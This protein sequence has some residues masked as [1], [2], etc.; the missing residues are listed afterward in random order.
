LTNSAGG[1]DGVS[2]T[3]ENRNTVSNT[4]QYVHMEDI[5]PPAGAKAGTFFVTVIAGA[6]GQEGQ[7][8]FDSLYFTP[9]PGRF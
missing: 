2:R 1:A 3:L 9:A 8:Y 6:A 5:V 4:W 7:A